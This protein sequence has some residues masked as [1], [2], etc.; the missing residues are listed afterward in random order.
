MSPKARLSLELSEKRQKLNEL[1]AVAPDK[2]TKEQRE[3][4]QT[5]S[6]RLQEVEVEL[7][8]AI[9]AEET[10]ETRIPGTPEEREFRALVNRADL[11]Q[12]FGAAMTH[13]HTDGATQE[14]Q[15][16]HELNPNQVPLD[17]LETRQA[18]PGGLETRDVTPAPAN[19]GQNQAPIIPAVFPLAVASFLGV[20]MPR[21]AV[22]DSIFPVLT[23]RATVGGPH[24][25]STAVTET[26]GAFDAEVLN[27]ARLQASF[28]WKRTDAAR[29][30]GLGESLRENLNM[31]LGDA[32]DQQVISG[33]NGLL[34]GTNLENHAASG[35][36][37]FPTYIKELAFGR[38]DGIYAGMVG[39]LRVVVGAAT[40]G[41]AGAVY[42]NTSVDR[43]ALDRLMDLTGGVRVSAHVP[44]PAS[45]KQNAIIRRGMRRDMVAPMWQGVTLIPDEV[46]KAATGEIV[47]TAVLL[48]AVKII[49]KAGF[50]KQETQ[51]A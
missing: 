31:A 29:F 47:V 19:V 5:L 30:A 36:T 44:V 46:T 15:Q 10:A 45:N 23:S 28:F 50:Y 41:H 51:H 12:I 40:Y 8:A 39:D 33:A 6:G 42:R 9:V 21:V 14:L 26:T 16:H 18:G 24:T 35:V 1:L 20:D 38:V 49:R 32:L 37:D 43:T 22:G 25:D 27:P 34:T 48:H 13:G 4:M 11:G 2:L 3:E 7:R 17:L